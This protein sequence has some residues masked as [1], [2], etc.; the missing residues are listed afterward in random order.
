MSEFNIIDQTENVR[1]SDRLNL[2]HLGEKCSDQFHKTIAEVKNI[3]ANTDFPEGCEINVVLMKLEMFENPLKN[4][5]LNFLLQRFEVPSKTY[6][7]LSCKSNIC[8]SVTGD[9]YMPYLTDNSENSLYCETLSALANIGYSDS[10]KISPI[11]HKTNCNPTDISMIMSNSLKHTGQI[12]FKK[13]LEKYVDKFIDR[14]IWELSEIAKSC[15]NNP[16]DPDADSDNNIRKLTKILEMVTKIRKYKDSETVRNKLIIMIRKVLLNI[17]N[18]NWLLESTSIDN[19]DMIGSTI[20]I[21]NSLSVPIPRTKLYDRTLDTLK[22]NRYQIMNK[23]LEKQFDVDI[24]EELTSNC[25][26]SIESFAKSA[27]NVFRN[28]MI[29][30]ESFTKLIESCTVHMRD[31]S[32]LIDT[33]VKAHNLNL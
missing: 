31:R 8:F 23:K 25:Q 30:L 32:A 3:L 15:F 4:N 21:L 22:K 29:S 17:I 2:Y 20:S 33:V 6:I 11:S 10:S 26:L 19:L 28:K 14:E 12:Y 16:C 24:F 5:T 18:Y 9:R 13:N 27:E 7:L 1:I